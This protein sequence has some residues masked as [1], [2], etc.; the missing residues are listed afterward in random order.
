MDARASWLRSFDARD[1]RLN[2]FGVDQYMTTDAEACQGS[3]AGIQLRRFAVSVP[4]PSRATS[5]PRDPLLPP[6]RQT[7]RDENALGEGFPGA[8]VDG[9]QAIPHGFLAE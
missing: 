6:L 4:S 5:T 9:R 3:N 8:C 7:A 1:G 2:C